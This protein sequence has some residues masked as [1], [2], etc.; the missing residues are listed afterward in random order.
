MT[1]T[2]HFHPFSSY[3]Q[4][5]LIALYEAGTPF[6]K[7]VVDLGDP[8]SASAFRALWPMGRFPVLVDDGRGATI[9]E[10]SIIIEYLD[11]HYL[12]AA[13]MLP[14]DAELRLRVRLLDR[15]V[16]SFVMTPMQKIVGDHIRPVEVR[17]PRGVGEARDLLARAY[18]WLENELAGR[19]WAA[20]DAFTMADCSAAPALFY[21]DLLA[22]VDAFPNVAAYLGRLRARPSFA[23]AVDE[24]RP[25][26]GFFP[27]GWPEGRD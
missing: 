24:A 13:R 26:R 21:A 15:F 12:G 10:S 14:D 7:H 22:P 16:D 1:L 5:V 11:E 25:F 4:K 27:P 3:C 23:R 17:D 19:T 18:G 20:G 9:P 6:E 2:L 8:A